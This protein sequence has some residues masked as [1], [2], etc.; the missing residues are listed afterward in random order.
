M[1]RGKIRVRWAR[2]PGF[3][4]VVAA[5]LI[6]SAVRCTS[7]ESC[8]SFGDPPAELSSSPQ[9]HCWGGK[10][11]G[12]WNDSDG[13]PRYAC[14]Y[15]P[16]SA[17]PNNRLPLVVFLHPSLL[18]ADSVKL[19]NLLG[20]LAS[21]EL[22]DHPSKRGFILLAP[23]GRKTSHYYPFPD[24][25]GYGWDNWYRQFNPAGDVTIGGTTYRENVDAAALDHF[26][27]QEVA[28]GKANSDRIFLT[29]WSNG[30]SMAIVYGLNRLYIAAIAV[31]SAPDPFGV[32]DDPCPQDPVTTPPKNQ[33]QIQIL[34]PHLS[35]MHVFN[36][37]DAAGLCANAHRLTNQL[38]PLGV[39]MDDVIINWLRNEVPSCLD[40]CGTDPNGDAS[41]LSNPL[42]AWLGFMNHARWPSSSTPRMLDFLRQHPLSAHQR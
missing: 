11:L 24:N 37:C 9:P 1:L 16:E 3:A 15:E 41:M 25:S 13:A 30:A 39:N 31:Y 26:I 38:R 34:N 2:A 36:N 42:G 20:S 40:A 18:P 22:S 29:G 23:E 28:T 21:A 5:I 33:H 7:A 19:T 27:A 12:P 6:G 4:L 10:L 17:A 8:S 14:L 32:L 35:M